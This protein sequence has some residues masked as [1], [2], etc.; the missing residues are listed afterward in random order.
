MEQKLPTSR[1]PYPLALLIPVAALLAA[2]GGNSDSGAVNTGNVSVS[3]V[4]VDGALQG[5]TVCLDLNDNLVCDPAEPRDITDSQGKYKLDTLTQTALDR[6]RL[7]ANVPVGAVGADDPANPVATAYTLTAPI[8]KHAAITPITTLIS[9][10]MDDD[11]GLTADEA[12]KVVAARIN[13]A[14]T[15]AELFADYTRSGGSKV[16]AYS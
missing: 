11:A 16:G 10:T 1:H 9:L 15:P 12:A 8:G 3:G 6:H 7:I 4:V 13:L 14:A 5:V 2:C